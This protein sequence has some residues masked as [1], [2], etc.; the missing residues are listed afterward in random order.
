MFQTRWLQPHAEGH[1]VTTNRTNMTK[2]IGVGLLAIVI[3]AALAS[4]IMA[5]SEWDPTVFIGFGG[6]SLKTRA[7]GEERLS[8]IHFRP[9]QGHDGKFFF[10]QANDPLVLDPAV[11]AENL[12]RPLYRSQRMLYPLLAGLGGL[13]APEQI[14]W[15]LLVVNLI[16]M[17]I[18]TWAV[19]LL[20]SHMGGSPWWGLA[21]VL[22]LGFVSEL[23][24]DGAGIAS[25]ALAFLAVLMVLRNRI[26]A[27]V[28]LLALAALSREAMLIAA[29]GSAFW[30]WRMSR[31]RD[32]VAVFLGPI[33]SVGLWAVYLRWQI[34]FESGVDQVQE[35]GLPFAGFF[36]AF[37]NWAGDPVDL[38]VGISMIVLMALFTR[39]VFAS[40]HLVGWAFLGFVPLGILFTQQVWGSWFDISRAI[41]P[42]LTAYVLLSFPGAATEGSR[43]LTTRTGVRL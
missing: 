24:I 21:F 12:D 22:N 35:L 38:M 40:A 14:V 13:L 3:S 42:I 33:T 17:G 26:P 23:S 7:Y 1:V 34:S 25:A 9:H 37:R 27:A 31:T 2:A 10:I 8:D 43:L 4:R 5:Q 16:F 18:G 20:A 19:A 11:H 32:A 6:E 30:L 39:R 15:S 41:A 36:G 29:A 28:A